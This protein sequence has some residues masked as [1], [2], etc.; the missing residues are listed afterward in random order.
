MAPDAGV[1]V[2]LPRIVGLRRAVVEY[3]SVVV[4]HGL[5]I[6]EHEE[7]IKRLETSR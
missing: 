5:M 4:G 1:S 3:H 7:R 6:S 2:T